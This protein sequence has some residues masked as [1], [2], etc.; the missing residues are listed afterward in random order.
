MKMA[1]LLIATRNRGKLAEMREMLNELPLELL[2]L[3]DVGITEGI[4]ETGETFAENAKLKAVAYAERAGI[5]TLA[6]DS[7]LVVDYLG[8]RP[9]VLSAR[10]AG[11]N[12][13]DQQRIEKLLAEIRE[14]RDG[15][16]AARFVCAVALADAAG[17]I[18]VNAEGTVHGTIATSPHGTNGFGYDPVFVPLGYTSTFGELDPHVKDK[19]S[20]RGQAIVKIIP[21]LRGFFKI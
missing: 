9:G 15:E 14:A 16:R 17:N 10:Y 4:E 21:F 13:D 6:D 2:D 3:N 5:P 20:H 8:G 18:C 7:G 12:A 11:I 1:K 19:L